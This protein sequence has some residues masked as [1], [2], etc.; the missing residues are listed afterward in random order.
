[1][2]KIIPIFTLVCGFRKLGFARTHS[3]KL[4]PLRPLKRRRQ[5]MSSLAFNLQFSRANVT[6]RFLLRTK[7][8]QALTYK[9][10]EPRAFVPAK[11]SLRLLMSS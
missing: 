10:P 11:K 5:V 2:R 8:A 3:Q 1:M 4:L 6:T 9:R 7:K